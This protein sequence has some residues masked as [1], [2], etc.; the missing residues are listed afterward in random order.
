MTSGAIVASTMSLSR[1]KKRDNVRCLGLGMFG[2]RET[3]VHANKVTRQLRMTLKRVR[4]CSISLQD[5]DIEALQ[6]L[7]VRQIK[8]WIARVFDNGGRRAPRL[9]G[10]NQ[11]GPTIKSPTNPRWLGLI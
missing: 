1:W 2:W 5:E 8:W 11:H 6:G 9:F 10:N 3:Q 7:Y 4:H